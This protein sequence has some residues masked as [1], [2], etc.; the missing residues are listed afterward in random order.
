MTLKCTRLFSQK[1][2]KKTRTNIMEYNS[3]L[4]LAR[5][6]QLRVDTHNNF[7]RLELLTSQILVTSLL[8]RASD[9]FNTFGT[10]SIYN[11]KA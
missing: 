8:K 3:H 11:Q 2:K 6:Q 5:N 7:Y 1:K 9:L 10:C 4:L